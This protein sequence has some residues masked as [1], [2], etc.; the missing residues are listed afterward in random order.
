MLFFLLFLLF[1]LAQLLSRCQIWMLI[2]TSE[3]L[4]Q[5]VCALSNVVRVNKRWK[6]K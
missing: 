4:S 1:S 3:L 5:L 2:R 6:K